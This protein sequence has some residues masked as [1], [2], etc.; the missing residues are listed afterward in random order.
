MPKG[1]VRPSPLTRLKNIVRPLVLG[2]KRDAR[3]G[4][5]HY[6][7]DGVRLFIRFPEECL[8]AAHRQLHFEQIYFGRYRP[9]GSDCVVDLG[10]GLGTEIVRL[11]AEAPGLRYVAVEIQ[12]W[13]YECL[14]LTLA[15][16]PAGFEPFGLAIGDQPSVRI[17]PSRDGLDVSVLGG[18]AVSVEA[19]DWTEF[20]RRHDIQRIDLLKMNIEGAEADLLDHADLSI[21]RRAIIAVHDFRADRGES[22]H[23]RTRARVENRLIAAGFAFEAVTP[24]WIYAERPA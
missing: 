2:V 15:Q 3:T 6:E 5:L 14:C 8:R 13:V 23:F 7:V 19:V 9:S 12:P 22:E 11:A 24:G 1:R 21:V 20:V 17:Q 4:H 16:L 10:A 18:G